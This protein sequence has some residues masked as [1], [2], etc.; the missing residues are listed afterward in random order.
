MWFPRLRGGSRAGTAAAAP[1]AAG[2]AH[3]RHP[4]NI[5]DPVVVTAGAELAGLAEGRRKMMGHACEF[6]TSMMLA[7]RP[8]LVR[9]GEVRDDPPRSD[10]AL[11]GLFLAED[12]WQRTD[13]GAVGYPERATAEKGRA[14]LE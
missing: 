11:R 3:S 9:R 12:M 7:L 6:E 2:E 1:L 8:E 4:P 10:A 5:T 13:H 14:F